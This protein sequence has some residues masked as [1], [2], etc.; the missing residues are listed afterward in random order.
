MSFILIHCTVSGKKSVYPESLK[1]DFNSDR[2]GFI[3]KMLKN[4]NQ[5]VMIPN[6]TYLVSV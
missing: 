2:D 5:D 1:F 4:D 6:S 3:Q